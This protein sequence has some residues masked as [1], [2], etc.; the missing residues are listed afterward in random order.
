ME[1]LDAWIPT[2]LPATPLMTGWKTAMSGYLSRVHCTVDT[3]LVW[4]YLTITLLS[5]LPPMLEMTMADK[6]GV[7]PLTRMSLVSVL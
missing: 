6:T 3:T 4:S 1:I 7:Q 2:R 5:I